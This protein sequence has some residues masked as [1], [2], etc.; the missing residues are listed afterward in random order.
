MFFPMK[1]ETLI[2]DI[3][4]LVGISRD[5]IDGHLG[6]YQGYVKHVNLIHEKI[7]AF[8]NDVE[9]NAY[10]IAE[11]QRRLGFE[12]C[13]M[14]NHEYYFA[15]LEGGAKVLPDGALKEKIQYQWGSVETWLQYFKQIAKTRGV[16]WVMLYHDPHTDQ[17]VHTWVDEQ[18]IG[19]LADLDIILALDMWEHSYMRDYKASE[20][21]SYVDAFFTNLNWE[22]VSERLI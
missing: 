19:Q 13:G 4:E 8:S 7:M 17:L 2:F 1:Y 9:N 14:R 18:H 22:V 5:T 15:Q 12:F 20:K 6:L 3:P 11:M 16:G 21:A 10:A